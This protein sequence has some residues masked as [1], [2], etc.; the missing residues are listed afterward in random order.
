MM[1]K[2]LTRMTK[3]SAPRY[4]EIREKYNN[5]VGSIISSL[6]KSLTYKNNWRNEFFETE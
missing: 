6:N 2:K 4:R 5:L 3:K 1:E